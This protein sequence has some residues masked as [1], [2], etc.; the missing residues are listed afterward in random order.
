[1][2]IN[3]RLSCFMTSFRIMYDSIKNCEKKTKNFF[4]RNME[5]IKMGFYRTSGMSGWLCGD[6]AR[7]KLHEFGGSK[8]NS[9]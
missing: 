9:Y 3:F 6:G 2:H 7:G 5:N 1:M 8:E 4:F